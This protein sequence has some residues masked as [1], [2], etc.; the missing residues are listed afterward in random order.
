MTK[1]YDELLDFLTAAPTPEQIITFSPSQPTRMRLN[2]LL[3]RKRAGVLSAEEFAELD[4]FNRA[5]QM[6]RRLICRAR[7][8]LARPASPF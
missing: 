7:Q 3:R 4:E 2:D 8:K 1:V 6:M 5:E